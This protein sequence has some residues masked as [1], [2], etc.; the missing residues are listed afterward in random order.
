MTTWF[1]IKLSAMQKMFAASGNTITRDE[2]TK[3]YLAAMPYTANEG[4][5][6]LSTA[7]KFIVKPIQITHNPVDNQLTS[8]SKLIQIV[9]GSEEFEAIGSKSYYFQVSGKCTCTIY[10][11]GTEQ[12]V[13]N[14]DNKQGFKAY[15]GN[16]LN[17][18]NEKVKIVFSTLY[19]LALKNVALY[20]AMWET[21]AE[22][23]EYGEKVK[24]RLKDIA[25]DFICLT[26][27]IF[28]TRA[29]ITL[30]HRHR[31]FGKKVILY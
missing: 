7:G 16:L 28:S 25:P 4:L 17:P 2:S 10:V 22:V 18:T 9:S 11:G 26:L 20:S 5:Q 19:P 21:D 29:M 15:K 3:D 12:I 27:Q 1:D 30:I 8:S 6:L 31:N 24:Y 14:I 13:L 23:Q